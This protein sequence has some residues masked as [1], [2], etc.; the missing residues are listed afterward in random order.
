MEENIVDRLIDLEVINQAAKESGL[1][2]D[3]MIMAQA[4]LSQKS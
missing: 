4:E 2:A 1:L 3:P